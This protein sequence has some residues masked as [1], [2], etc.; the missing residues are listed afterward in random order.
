M[1]RVINK[2]S[3]EINLFGEVLAPEDET[4]IVNNIFDTK[5]AKNEEL[6]VC[7]ITIQYGEHF[8]KCYGKMLCTPEKG[9]DGTIFTISEK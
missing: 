2:T 1:Y 8:S 3:K 7:E 6:G 4:I 9:G 5:S